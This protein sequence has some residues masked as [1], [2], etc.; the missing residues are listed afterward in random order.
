MMIKIVKRR[1][2]YMLLYANGQNVHYSLISPDLSAHILN[3][4]KAAHASL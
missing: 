2:C 1:A 3:F 4:S